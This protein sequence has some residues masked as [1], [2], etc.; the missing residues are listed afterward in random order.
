MQGTELQQDTVKAW[1]EYIG[2]ANVRMQARLRPEI[3][4]LK[5]DEDQ[6]WI[7]NIQTGEIL[8]SHGG[9]QGLTRVPSG[10]IHDWFGAVF[11]PQTTLNNVLSVVRDYNRYKQFYQPTVVDS[12]TI[13]IDGFKDRFSMVLVDKS[14]VGE[15][16]FAGDYRCLNVRV[17]DRR[18]YSVSESTRIR[19][20]QSYGTSNEHMLQD[21]EGTGLLWRVFSIARFEERDGGVFVE[22]EVIALSRDVPASL[23][24]VVEPIVR[25]VSRNSLITSLRQTEDAVRAGRWLADPDRLSIAILPSRPF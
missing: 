3:P 11:I 23:R 7:S 16:A 8:I 6:H 18:W 20:I 25:R 15:T 9:S 5:V 10:L 13:S 4:F 19:E 21:G 2:S 17:N 14:L 24:W 12:K 22:F 1:Q